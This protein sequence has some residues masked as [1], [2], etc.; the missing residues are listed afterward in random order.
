MRI[1]GDMLIG[2]AAVRGTEGTLHAFDPARDVVLEPAFG[3]GGA[4]D[5]DRACRL[6]QA[7][8]DPFRSV[9]LDLRARFLETIAENVLALGSALIERAHQESA[10][11]IGRL[12]AERGRTV[13]QLRLFASFVREGRWLAA[14]IEPA[15][16]ER[17]PLP[18]ADLRLQKIP[19]G[20]VAVFG[21][22]NFPLAFS[23]AGGDTA[24]AFAAGCPVV[25]KAHPAHLGASELVGRAIQQAVHACGLPEGT[26]SLLTGSGNAIG[27]ALVAHPAIKAVGF[28]GS[29]AGGLALA[30]V[31]ANRREPIP[32]YAEMSSV[33]PFFVL[34]G[35]LAKRAADI[36]RGLVDSL[37]LG[38][39]QF[40]T[41]PGIVVLLDGPDTQTFIDAVAQALGQ[42]GAQTMLTAGIAAAY[43]RG[44]AERGA[45]THVRALAHGVESEA[46]HTGRPVLFAT[47]QPTFISDQQLGDEIFG[48]T[49]LIVTCESVDEM[50]ELAEH[51]D[52][53]LTATLHVEAE[54]LALARRLLPT[55]E[56]KAGR[57]LA[58]GYPTGVEVSHAMVHGGP[59][60]AT[61]DPRA[62][63]VGTMAIER[64]LRPVCYQD[65][66]AALLPPALQDD[67]PLD[68]WRVRDGKLGNV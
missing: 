2:R 7:A 34:P 45:T 19:L 51:V 20:P 23:V 43:A 10:L 68:L 67:N 8:F 63:S 50:L 3:T 9:S 42:K 22:S 30:N 54:D 57:I 14:T 59:C 13:A 40:C 28:T 25:V 41:N 4:H 36:A 64:F 6:A 5:V 56:R 44:V 12:E 52:G 60:P 47:T 1:T 49:S 53:Q 11:P 61:S 27:E 55:L 18:R 65:L 26:F 38:V 62:T 16:P 39:G 32:V 17:K 24:S 35:A 15:Q 37:T 46:L 58:N 33:N 21:A 66:P 29:R 31:A 48:P